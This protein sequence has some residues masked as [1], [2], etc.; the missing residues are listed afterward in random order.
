MTGG[1]GRRQ[2][3]GLLQ[4]LGWYSGQSGDLGPLGFYFVSFGPGPM[5]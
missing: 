3:L 2:E 5:L 1:P 4:L